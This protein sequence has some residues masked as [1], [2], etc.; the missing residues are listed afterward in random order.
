MFKKKIC[1]QNIPVENESA[2]YMVISSSNRSDFGTIF[3]GALHYY[4]N[5]W[6]C[7]CSSFFSIILA[8]RMISS[9]ASKSTMIRSL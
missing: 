6:L 4:V 7:P 5:L 8:F 9:R 1:F 3:L 2:Y